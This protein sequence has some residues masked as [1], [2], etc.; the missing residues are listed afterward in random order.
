M[1]RVLAGRRLDR[2]EAAI[3]SGR[4]ILV[5]A[6]LLELERLR[7]P[8]LFEPPLPH[9]YGRRAVEYLAR[10]GEPFSRLLELVAGDEV[11][12]A[13]ATDLFAVELAGASPAALGRAWTR[14]EAEAATVVEDLVQLETVTAEARRSVVAPSASGLLQRIWFREEGGGSAAE[15]ARESVPLAEVEPFVNAVPWYE[16]VEDAIERL[17]EP[18]ERSQ[19]MARQQPGS[20]RWTPIDGRFRPAADLFVVPL[21]LRALERRAAIGAS[22]LFRLVSGA[23]RP[24]PGRLVLVRHR[25]I[26]DPEL[27]G[28]TTVRLW[29]GLAPRAGEW[30]EMRVVLR[31]ASD[32]PGFGPM[33]LSVDEGDLDLIAEMVEVLG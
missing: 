33:E 16:S 7:T 1:E 20:Y 6:A 13:L 4:Q 3:R 25:D 32:D 24:T 30:G 5:R 19:D 12:P 18:E 8:S 23:W 31:P 28:S 9:G 29:D 10:H 27:G 14:L 15:E 21:E 11:P 17:G 22:C 26:L 2:H